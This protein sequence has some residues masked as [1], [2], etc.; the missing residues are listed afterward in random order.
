LHRFDD[1]ERAARA[2]VAVV[3]Y[4]FANTSQMMEIHDENV[5]IG[6]GTV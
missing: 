2:L 4:P 1:I 3:R 5:G 6:F